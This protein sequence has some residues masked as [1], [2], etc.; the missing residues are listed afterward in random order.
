VEQ[1]DV[2]ENNQTG[3]VFFSSRDQATWFGGGPILRLDFKVSDRMLLSTESSVYST[4]KK[5]TSEISINGIPSE[6]PSS[7]AFQLLLALPQSLYFNVCF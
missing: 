1:S 4:Y 7:T 2:T 6:D 3:T 5:T